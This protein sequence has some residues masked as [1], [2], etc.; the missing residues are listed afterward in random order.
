MSRGKS[1]RLLHWPVMLKPRIESVSRAK[2]RKWVQLIQESSGMVSTL[3]LWSGV[4]SSYYSSGDSTSCGW[5]QPGY[6]SHYHRQMLLP[7]ITAD[8]PIRKSWLTLSG[9]VVWVC[10]VRRPQPVWFL[11]PS[12]L[13]SPRSAAARNR[14]NVMRAIMEELVT[15]TR[16]ESKNAVKKVFLNTK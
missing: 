15:G 10:S 14:E 12:Q 2:Q 4:S 6:A 1:S 13:I 16:S 9:S 3:C 7:T 11:L 8:A 5:W